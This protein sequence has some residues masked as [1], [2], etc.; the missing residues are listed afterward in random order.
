MKMKLNAK[1]LIYAAVIGLSVIALVLTL[2]NYEFTDTKL[3]Y[4]RF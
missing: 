3:V 1:T 4:Q 2:I